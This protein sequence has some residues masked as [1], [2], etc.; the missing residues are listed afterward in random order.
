VDALPRILP[1]A[2]SAINSRVAPREE[3]SPEACAIPVRSYT[4]WDP[5]EEVIVGR[6]DGA[7]IPPSHVSVTP[8]LP[9]LTAKVYRLASGFRYPDWMVRLAQRE[10]DEFIHILE[11][12]GVTVRRPDPIDFSRPFGAPQWTSRGFST[13]CPRDTFLI[14]GDEIIETPSCWRSRYFESGA[15]RSLFKEYFL[16]GARWTAAPRPQ[17]TEELFDYD[18]QIPGPSEPPRFVVNE[19]EPVFDA[20]DFV[21]CGRDLFVT[22]SNVTNLMGIEWLRR[23]LG[24]EFKIHELESRSRQP[25]HIDSS[26]MP[27]APGKVLVNPD[28]LDV[29]HLPPILNTWDV[30]VAPR[31]DPVEGIMS[32]ISMCSPWVSINVFMLD[33]ERAVVDMSQVTLIKALKEWGFTPIPC[34]FMNYGPFGG[35]FHCATLDVRRRGNL[36]SY[37]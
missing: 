6:L 16:K 31:P 18:Y 22:R 13:A 4:E 29:E 15:Y 25:M 23:H 26:F 32:K 27:L 1:D 8:N 11:S 14:V 30:L 9:P 19:F 28:Y 37:F 36:Q 33:T 20:A 12:E 24:A 17:L 3:V 2:V 5:L 35:A 34:R 7:T 21:R 10:L